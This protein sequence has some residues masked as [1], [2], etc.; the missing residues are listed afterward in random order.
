MSNT[1]MASAATAT[2]VGARRARTSSF[3][4]R[5]FESRS[6][7]ENT[8]DEERT[9]K[10]ERRDQSGCAAQRRG[11]RQLHCNRRMVVSS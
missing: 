6:P 11:L 9:M 1:L 7:S 8:P 2:A 3:I 5:L 10:S 4:L